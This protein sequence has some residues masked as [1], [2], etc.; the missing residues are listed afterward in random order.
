MQL[1][2]L[3]KL[4]FIAL[5]AQACAATP[6]TRFYV[7]ETVSPLA[8]TD[9]IKTQSPIIGI[10]PI[11]I[12]TLLERKQIVNRTANNNVEFAEFDQWASPLKDNI[13]QVLR[14]NLS[15]L[16]PNKLF[17]AYPWAAFG[18]VDFRLVIEVTQFDAKTGELANL[19]ANWTLINEK[20]HN[21]INNGVYKTEQR[22]NDSSYE[23]MVS[24]LN[25]LLAK[26]SQQLA[27][28]TNKN[29][30]R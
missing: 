5:A 23:S 19:E 6:P 1:R 20:N 11:T 22:L 17:R 10:G 21:I 18:G 3:C 14:G 27:E 29:I 26:L 7:L 15:H 8:S 30:S 25:N 9:P 4:V 16:V 24:A 2:T 12:P 28:A 13:V